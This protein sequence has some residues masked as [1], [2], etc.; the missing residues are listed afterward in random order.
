MEYNK[1]RLN[2]GTTY[3]ENCSNDFKITSFRV[4]NGTV[5]LINVKDTKLHIIYIKKYELTS[6]ILTVYVCVL[7]IDLK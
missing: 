6:S 7:D 1:S 3:F 4:N 2:V 5:F